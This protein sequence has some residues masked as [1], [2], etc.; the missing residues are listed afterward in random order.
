MAQFPNH[1]FFTPPKLPPL[2]LDLTRLS[3]G[4]WCPAEFEGETDDGRHVYCRYRGGWV[5]V[6]VGNEPGLDAYVDEGGNCV[7]DQR[8]GPPYHGGLSLGQLCHYVGISINGK[9]PPLPTE[10]E[11]QGIY[12]LDDL[13]DLSGDVV[14]YELVQYSM[15]STTVRLF[16][17]LGIKPFDIDERNIDDRHFFC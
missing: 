10:A 11:I 1:R 9:M 17:R 7:V 13:K 16:E 6:W 14:F 5:Q 3:G 8:I 4:G 15:P 12:R 2:N